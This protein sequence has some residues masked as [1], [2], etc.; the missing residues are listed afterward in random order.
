[1]EVNGDEC[2]VLRASSLQISIYF[3]FY[4]IFY[5]LLHLGSDFDTLYLIIAFPMERLRINLDETMH[6]R[7][8]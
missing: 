2:N 6:V 7:Q 1:M 4:F 3:L 8:C 5:F